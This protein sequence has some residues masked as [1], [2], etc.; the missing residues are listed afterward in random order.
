[1]LLWRLHNDH[2]DYAD[3]SLQI[4]HT[5][6]YTIRIRRG[7]DLKFTALVIDWRAA[8]QVIDDRREELLRQGWK[9]AF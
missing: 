8:Q 7:G 3:C 1:M 9:H 6:G 5:G 4:T 2:D